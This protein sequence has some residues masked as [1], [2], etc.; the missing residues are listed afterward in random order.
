MKA[1]VKNKTWEVMPLPKNRK[2]VGCRWVFNVKLNSDGSLE[3]YKARLVA[4][5]YTQTYGI[6]YQETFAPV[7]KLNTIRI[8]LSIAA[9]LEWPL[10]QLDVKNAFLNGEL[11][12]EVFMDAPPGFENH[13]GGN[14]CRLHKSLYGLK[15]SPRAWFEKFS[16]SVKN[17]GYTQGQS[18]HTMFIKSSGTGKVAVL[19][20]YVDDIIISG[21]DEEE[22]HRLKKCL[23]SEFE[24]KDLG[25]LRYFLGM[26]V[27]RSKKGIYVSQRKYILDL[28]KDTGMTG[29]RPS[30]T[31]IDPN[32]K[33]GDITQGT[34]VDVG[35]YQRLV[36]KL[37]YL[38][39]TRPDIAFAVS[40][41]S[42]FMHSPYE[43][44]LDAVYKILRYLKNTPGK[45]LLF[46]RCSVRNIEGFT[47][48]DWAGSVTDRRSTSGYCIFLWGNLVTWRSKKQNVVAR[49]SAEAELRA[50]ANGVC[51]L[52]WVRR[53]LKEL[54]LEFEAPMKLFCDNKSAINIANNPV[55]HDRTKHI[56]IDRHFIKE[57]LEDGSICMP[58]VPSE[59]QIADGFTKG[60]F[61]PKFED[62]TSKLGM[63]D[64][65]APT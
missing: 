58:Y 2:T 38:S 46:K 65:F 52:L 8:L 20:V 39:H 56:E 27:A 60:N 25:P 62:F 18:D 37:I 61:R 28:L 47:D 19:I 51:E 59:Q 42:Q 50:V 10:H 7:A 41:V 34:P 48:A 30:D 53:V 11:E 12:E 3:R 54:Q 33:L 22:I 63:V 5:G 9:N 55:Q 57:K 16:K 29:C 15:Q 45:G 40:M 21:N 6:D 4:R 64:I 1:L 43:E 24:V 36:G 35:R 13:F 17:Q 49:S 23:S 32:L 31:P 44:H 14:V 26:E